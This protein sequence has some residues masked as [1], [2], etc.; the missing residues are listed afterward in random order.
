MTKYGF[1]EIDI[2][3]QLGCSI[4]GYFE[5]RIIDDI[6]TPLYAKSIVADDGKKVT[7]ICVIDAICVM[8]DMCEKAVSRVVK[9][10][11]LDPE[12]ILI[13]ATHIHTGGP[14][15]PNEDADEERGKRY[16]EWVADKIS[17]CI[18]LAYRRREEMTAVFNMKKVYDISF[19]RNYIM[20]DG[21][22]RTNPEFGNKDIVKRVAEADP[23]MPYLFFKD[24]SGKARGALVNFA[25]HHDCVHGTAV[26][27]DYS[28][29]LAKELREHF[30]KDFI[31][32]FINGFCGN[33]NNWDCI[34]G[35]EAPPVE[36]HIVMGK[37][38]AKALIDTLD[39]AKAMS[40]ER[41]DFKQE[42]MTIKRREIAPE[43]IEKAKEYLNKERV[44]VDISNAQGDSYLIA[45]APSI[46]R[47]YGD[48]APKEFK[49][50]SQA[51][52]LGDCLIYALPGEVHSQ[53]GEY[54][55]QN[56]PTD[57]VFLAELANARAQYIPIAELYDAKNVYEAAPTACTLCES[58]GME[59]SEK[60]VELGNKL[61]K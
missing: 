51:I 21:S 3:P 4:P 44:A 41:V 38:L 54:I 9:E 16:R 25:C 23:D 17:D 58:G 15:R 37:T 1:Y 11:G 31:S 30:G 42:L 26:S 18:I 20:A 49:L 43:I 12:G 13:Q 5:Q 35:T 10:I 29:I 48:D 47:I 8:D 57:K 6:L 53:Y 39:D 55:K 52:R 45:T 40:D 33:I 59:L 36:N 27:S 19:V 60:A 32:V 14:V 28:G 46:I 22:V 24:S 61:F 50:Y 34:K 2:T 7:A 56:A